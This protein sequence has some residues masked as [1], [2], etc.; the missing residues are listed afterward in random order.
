MHLIERYGLTKI[1]VRRMSGVSFHEFHNQS[2]NDTQDIILS[3]TIFG[4][5]DYIDTVETDLVIMH[6]DR[7]EAMACAIV[8]ATRYVRCGHIEVERYL[9]QLTKLCDIAT[10]SSH[11]T[12]L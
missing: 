8:C 5:S 11:I 7:V 3:K 1:E 10:Q 12:T 4:F 2:E 9:A 6:G